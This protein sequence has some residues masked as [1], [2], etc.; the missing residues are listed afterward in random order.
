MQVEHVVLFVGCFAVW[1]ASLSLNVYVPECLYLI[2]SRELSNKDDQR[3][4]YIIFC[5]KKPS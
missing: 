4:I 3:Y 2:T 5:V 1:Q